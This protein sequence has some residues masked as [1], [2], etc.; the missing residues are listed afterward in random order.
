MMRALSCSALLLSAVS[1]AAEGDWPSYNRTLTSE[2]LAPQTQITGANVANLA[3]ICSYDVAQDISLQTGPI[4][5]D[6]TLYGTTASDTFAIDAATCRQR[7]RV[8]AN[9]AGFIKVNRGVAYAPGRVIRGLMDGRVIAYDAKTGKELWATQISDPKLAETI[10]AAPIVWD[11]RVYVGNAGGDFYGVKGRMYALDVA[12]GKI[13]WEYYLVPKDHPATRPSGGPNTPEGIR[14]ATWGNTAEFPIS[15]GATWTSYTIDPAT[16]LLYVPGGNPG[17][18]FYS[19]VRPGANLYAGSV[20]VLDA[21]SGTYRAHYEIVPADYHDWDV[22]ATPVVTTTRAGKKH[23]LIAPKDGHLY[24]YDA[25]AHTRRFATPVTTIENIDAPLTKEGTRFCPGAQG[26]VEWNGPAY[27]PKTNLVMTG[28]ADWCTTVWLA[29]KAPVKGSQGM[30]WTGARAQNMFGKQDPPEKWGGW[31]VATD[32]DTGTVKWRVRTPAPPLAGITPT[33]SGITFAGDMG[34]NF[35]ALDTA[36]G[37][38]LAKRNLGGALGGGIISYSAGDAQRVAVI[39]GTYSPIWPVPK[40]MS[41]IVVF[42]LK[43]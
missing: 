25:I 17:P 1:V 18:D 5:V 8:T 28:A 34:G 4:V 30:P 37:K 42:G 38:E 14:D 19:A 29:E 35:Y 41:K 40:A 21:K 9:D 36:T 22:S 12:T 24:G 27:D 2:R 11:G 43:K 10:P 20:I 33:A 39:T 6:G 16:G 32:A 31:I 15:G 23:V 26:G 13:V 7:W 3:V